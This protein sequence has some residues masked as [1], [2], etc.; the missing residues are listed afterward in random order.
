MPLVGGVDHQFPFLYH[1]VLSFCHG[2]NPALVHIHQLSHGVGLSRE[3]E[4]RLL[5][6]QEEGVK[7][8]H[9]HPRG[10]PVA[11]VLHLGTQ[12]PGKGKACHLHGG[13]VLHRGQG[14]PHPGRE[15]HP[16]VQEE[17][18]IGVVVQGHGQGSHALG[19]SQPGGG[20]GLV[21]DGLLRGQG[22]GVVVGVVGGAAAAGQYL[23]IG[24]EG[25]GA[26]IL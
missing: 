22:D 13:G 18:P 1:Q 15:L 20:G 6:L 23:P 11:A 12:A 10:N 7:A 5:L 16:P 14:E 19:R 3:Q 25:L 26:E 2:V 24:P 9:L 17:I 4:A 21:K 8:L